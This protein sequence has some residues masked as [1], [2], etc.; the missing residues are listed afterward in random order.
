M[1]GEEVREGARRRREAD[2]ERDARALWG[3]SPEYTLR[4]FFDMCE[5]TRKLSRARVIESKGCS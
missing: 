2:L 5:F 1:E 3:R 4:M